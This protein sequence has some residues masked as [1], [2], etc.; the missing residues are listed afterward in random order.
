[1]ILLTLLLAG[2]AARRGRRFARGGLV[3]LG[4]LLA[5]THALSSWGAG[6]TPGGR[7]ELCVPAWQAPYAADALAAEGEDYVHYRLV[8][9]RPP[10][11][12][13]RYP[14]VAS[15]AGQPLSPAR[16]PIPPGAPLERMRLPIARVGS[17]VVTHFDAQ[18]LLIDPARRPIRVV[19]PCRPPFAYEVQQTAPG[20][21]LLLWAL[22]LLASLGLTRTRAAAP[23]GDT[24]SGAGD[25]SVDAASGSDVASS[26]GT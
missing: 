11:S 20:A 19:A 7:A 6:A 14:R 18:F 17:D 24:T 13:A 5:G 22:V 9:G 25:S 3:G 12:V 10:R 26:G 15:E 1:M 4:L 2:G 23:P 16:A 21:Q 8:P